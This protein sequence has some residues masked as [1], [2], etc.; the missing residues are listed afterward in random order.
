[1]SDVYK[2]FEHAGVIVEIV[3]DDDPIGNPQENDNAGTIYSWTRDFSGDERISEPFMSVLCP[4]CAGEGCVAIEYWPSG[5]EQGCHHCAETG[6]VASDDLGQILAEQGVSVPRMT[7]PLRFEDWRSNGARIYLCDTEDA[8]AAIVFT[9]D[10]IDSEWSGRI[11]Q[12][13]DE[14]GYPGAYE[15]AL[16]RINELDEWLQGYTYGIV[17]RERD[18][19]IEDPEDDESGEILESVWGFIGDPSGE[20]GRYIMDEARSLAEYCGEEIREERAEV[21][22]WRARDVET[23]A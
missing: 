13:D 3:H 19:T 14:T 5:A 16:A 9:Q 17:I 8:N 11:K 4:I 23:I 20:S 21:E 2:R 22:Y 18:E 15:Y 7:L 12:G 10:E 6:Y 1:M